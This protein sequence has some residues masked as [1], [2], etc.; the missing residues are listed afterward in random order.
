MALTLIVAG[1]HHE[2]QE[3]AEEHKLYDWQ[4]VYHADTLQGLRGT[5]LIY[6]GSYLR[7]PHL[8]DIIHMAAERE[9]KEEWPVLGEPAY[10]PDGTQVLIG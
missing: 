4:Y 3:Y 6:V 8:N 10:V 1:R 9:F 7:N 2:A 5:R